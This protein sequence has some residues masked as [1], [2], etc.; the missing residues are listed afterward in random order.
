M[1][2]RV[3]SQSQPRFIIQGNMLNLDIDG[4]VYDR[5]FFHHF[6]AITLVDFVRVINPQDFWFQRVL[7]MCH[8]A[9]AVRNAVVALGAAHYVYLQKVQNSTSGGTD[10]SMT[11]YEC[12]A[13]QYYNKAIGE[14]VKLKDGSDST[15]WDAQLKTLIC[16]LLFVCL[17]N[18]L[19]RFDEGVRHMH[20][21]ARLFETSNFSDAPQNLQYIMQEI[22]TV[23]LHFSVDVGYLNDDFSGPNLVPHAL[24]LT[25]IDDELRPFSSLQEAKEAIWVLDVKMAYMDYD[26]DPNPPPG[27]ECIMPDFSCFIEPY[28]RWRT[29]FN[30]LVA[31]QVDSPDVPLDIQRETLNLIVRRCSWDILLLAEGDNEEELN[32]LNHE[33]VDMAELL[34]SIEESSLG[35]PMFTLEGDSI[36]ALY[37]VGSMSEDPVLIGRIATLLRNSRRREG[38]WDGR[39][40]AD[41]LIAELANPSPCPSRNAPVRTPELIM[42][43]TPEFTMDSTPELTPE[44][45][46][47]FMYYPV[48]KTEVI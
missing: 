47:D 33:L 21:G 32:R 6:R 3:A 25:E 10:T 39:A 48:L 45:I 13:T 11:H 42:D 20:A 40:A 4:G 17:E 16:C 35:R 31:S 2:Q 29:R 23:L 37:F 8:E 7:P 14:L 19:G 30:L 26:E 12:V 22:A 34:Y 44:P 43:K 1:V 9:P 46:P 28:Q 38:P 5:M 27:N 24:P 41:R 15:L 18:I 36:P